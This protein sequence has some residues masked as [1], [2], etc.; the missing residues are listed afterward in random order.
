MA[1]QTEDAGP[2][3]GR[4]RWSTGIVVATRRGSLS[5]LPQLLPG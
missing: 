4:L 1:F 5:T 3:L 2:L